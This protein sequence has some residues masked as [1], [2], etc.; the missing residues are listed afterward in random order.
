[1]KLCVVVLGESRVTETSF[2]PWLQNDLESLRWF[3]YLVKMPH[4]RFSREVL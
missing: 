2:P 3:G 4:E 1:M